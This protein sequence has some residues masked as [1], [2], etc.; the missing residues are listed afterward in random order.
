MSRVRLNL[1]EADPVSRSDKDDP[2]GRLGA[3]AI[4][5]LVLALAS[6]N[7]VAAPK[8]GRTVTLIAIGSFSDPSV[9]ALADHLRHK[10]HLRVLL[11]GSVPFPSGTYDGSRK[12]YV[13]E[14]LLAQLER[15]YSQG[16]AVAVTDRDIYMKAKQFRYVFSI[17]NQRAAVVSSAR[18]DP[19]FYGLAPDTELWYSRLDK[20]VG[21]MV[22]VLALGRRESGNP[23]SVLYNAILGFDDLDFMTEDFKPR[24]YAADKRAWLA[25]ADTA[26]KKAR[27]DAAAVGS[28]PKQT[29][30]QLL[31]IVTD[32]VKLEGNLLATINALPAPRSDRALV[33]KLRSAFAQAVSADQA[34]V[35][36]LTAHWDAQK[37]KDFVTAYQ[38]EGL[39]LR[40]TSLRLGSRACADYFG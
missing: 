17:R 11:R 28:R 36:G 15:A 7:A 12:Q 24:P 32:L 31:A 38:G 39:G 3:T 27:A 26:C 8:A 22:G 21:K 19:R 13:G 4:L 23:R 5:V 6:S 20:M 30:E 14:K 40:A 18:M 1:C 33:A 35:A 9:K 2:V 10:F 29:S 25:S 34:A 37:F 16:V